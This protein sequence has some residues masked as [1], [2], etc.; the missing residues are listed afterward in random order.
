MRRD[1]DD[2]IGRRLDVAASKSEPK[3]KPHRRKATKGRFDV[4]NAFVD[5]SM[6]G[7]SCAA[8]KTWFTLWRDTKPD[9]TA[10]TGQADIATRAGLT[11]RSV[12]RALRQLEKRGLVE[13][14]RRGKLGSGPSIY[15]VHGV[16][17]NGY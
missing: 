10:K 13:F 6:A 12:R 1:A 3:P 17:P 14:L 7:L 16:P 11:D 15:R 9:G 2:Y 5:C 8:V 4:V